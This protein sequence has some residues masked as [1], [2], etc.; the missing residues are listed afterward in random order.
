VYIKLLKLEGDAFDKEYAR[1]MV[2]DHRDDVKEFQEEAKTGKNQYLKDFA[3]Q[4]LPTLQEHL[5]QAQEL[6]QTVGANAAM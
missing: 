1:L 2:K 5:K 3:G 4:T 6:A